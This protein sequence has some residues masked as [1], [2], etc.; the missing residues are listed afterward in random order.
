MSRTLPV[1]LLATI[2]PVV[3]EA[4][5]M[6][7]L[8]DLPEAVVLRYD[9]DF[10]DGEG[11]VRRTLLAASGVIE[12]VRQPLEH[13]CLSC[14]VRY[15]AVPVLSRLAREGRWTSVLMAL[16]VG[17]DCLPVARALGKASGRGGELRGVRLGSAL[18]ALSLESFTDDLLGDDLLD[19]RGLAMT[20][21]DR[22]AVGEALGAQVLHADVVV[23]SGNARE[24]PTASALVD[25][26]RG[27]DSLRVD[28]LHRADLAAMMSASHSLAAGD[29]RA[30]PL[31]MTPR[32]QVPG[33]AVWSLELLSARPFHPDRLL[34]RIEELGGGRL[35]SRGVFWVPTRPD[36][37]CIWEGA[38]GQLSI[39]EQGPW[40]HGTAPRTRLVIVGAGDEA[41]RLRSAFVDSLMTREEWARGLATWLGRPDVLAPWLGS[42][43]DGR[44]VA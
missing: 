36:S 39:G 40:P 22:R 12:D 23:T 26:V 32:P 6:N 38:G 16:P 10:Q 44:G 8:L 2:D 33:R 25:S 14:A 28:G 5:T 9:F 43:H 29:A 24:H 41:P 21:D 4:V 30:D 31:N 42:R 17:A 3:R 34:D 37:L 1:S 7:A 15:D 35:Y 20:P 19:E 13:A 18:A 11:R 27:V